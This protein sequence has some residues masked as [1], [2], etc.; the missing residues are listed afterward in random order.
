MHYQK[1]LRILCNDDNKNEKTTTLNLPSRLT[2]SLNEDINHE[3]GLDQVINDIATFKKP[4]SGTGNGKFE[5]NSEHYKDYSPYFYHYYKVIYLY[6][7][8]YTIH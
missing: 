2:K 8:I 1:L 3:T 6:I 5:L 7:L 4:A